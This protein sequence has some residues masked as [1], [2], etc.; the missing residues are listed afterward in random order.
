MK[1][2]KDQIRPLQ[3]RESKKIMRKQGKNHINLVKVY[4]MFDMLFS[5]LVVNLVVL[6]Q[7]LQFSA[8]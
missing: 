2:L 1:Q 5:Y 3:S 8:Q 6:I 4:T 7:K